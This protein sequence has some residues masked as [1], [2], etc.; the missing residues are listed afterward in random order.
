MG[1]LSDVI[2]NVFQDC[3]TCTDED[4]CWNNEDDTRTIA[5]RQLNCIIRNLTGYEKFKEP[6]DV[7]EE[8]ARDGRVES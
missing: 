4:K 8:Y 5:T 6:L 1:K 2:A 7:L 3:Y